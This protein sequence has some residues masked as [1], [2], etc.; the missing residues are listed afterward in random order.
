MK[1]VIFINYLK[2]LKN[3]NGFLVAWYFLVYKK[4]N[5][6]S[7]INILI[8]TLNEENNRIASKKLLIN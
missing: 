6:K 1:V 8:S 3:L 2:P 4:L 5:M 7:V